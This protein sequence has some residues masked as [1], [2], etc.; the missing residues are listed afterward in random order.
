MGGRKSKGEGV[1]KQIN[2]E[3]DTKR[4]DRRDKKGGMERASEGERGRKGVREGGGE[5]VFPIW[6][7]KNKL[8]VQK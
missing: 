6:P 5:D 8:R 1:R 3:Q 2:W 7:L 4:R